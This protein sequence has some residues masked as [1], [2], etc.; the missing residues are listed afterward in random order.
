MTRNKNLYKDFDKQD[1]FSDRLT[2]F[3]IHFAFFFKVYKNKDNKI[4][5]Q[6]IYD[7]CF[8]QL[9]LTIR[10][11]GYGDQSI[12][13]KMKDYIN[14][15]HEMIDKF[16]FWDDL[17]EEEKSKIL[18]RFATNSNNIALLLDYFEKYLKT[19]KKNT[20]NSYIKSVIKS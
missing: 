20:L 13:K 8:R 7:F 16:H 9:E 5:L 10:E 6:E 4:I 12:N 2:Y 17:N 18:N 14:L 1:N 11:I 19:L 3:L 15:F